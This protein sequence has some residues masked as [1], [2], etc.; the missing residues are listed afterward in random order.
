MNVSGLITLQLGLDRGKIS[1]IILDKVRVF[2]LVLLLQLLV[3]ESNFAKNLGSIPS[4]IYRKLDSAALMWNNNNFQ[5]AE[6]YFQDTEQLATAVQDPSIAV[7]IA[8]QY[9]QFLFQQSRFLEATEQTKRAVDWSLQFSDRSKAAASL[10][11]IAL[12]QHIQGNL[13]EAIKTLLKALEL[14]SEIPKPIRKDLQNRR[15]YLNNLSAFLLDL[16]DLEKGWY[17]AKKSHDIAAELKDSLGMGSSLVN[18][19]VSEM[20][21]GR[22][23]EAEVHGNLLLMIGKQYAHASMQI[24]AYNNLAELY[25]RQKKFKTALSYYTKAY[26]ILKTNPSVSMA[27]TLIGFSTVYL[28]LKDYAKANSYF[29][30]A[31]TKSINELGLPDL[32][33][34]YHAGTKIKEALGLYPSALSLR[35]KY[36]LLRDS[37]R[38]QEN[39]RMVEELEMQYN[40]AQNK[41]DLSQRDLKIMEQQLELDR[42]NLW[43][44][45]SFSLLVFIGLLL[46]MHNMRRDLRKKTRL[47]RQ[48]RQL[49]QAQL[50]AVEKERSRTAKELHDGVASLLV[51]TKLQIQDYAKRCISPSGMVEIIQLMDAAIQE[52]RGISHNLAPEM[53]LKEG[54]P[55]AVRSYCS[56]MSREDQTVNCNIQGNLDALSKD[57]Q[58]HIYRIIQEAVSNLVK[59]AS[60]NEGFVQIILHQDQ[61]SI[62]IEDDGKGFRSDDLPST[63]LGLKNLRSRVESL[64]GTLVIMSNEREG[65]SLNIEVDLSKKFTVDRSERTVFIK[66]YFGIL[67]LNEVS[68]F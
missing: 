20:L 54:L 53:M 43:V 21:L 67:R 31:N 63:G 8:N 7:F 26:A 27:F 14:S 5:E 24:Q 66:P 65:T 58:L 13:Q 32:M 12:Q 37:I 59:H 64:G 15:K 9:S 36:D 17:Y 10:N 68:Q 51:A 35:K 30:L 57:M 61:L 38:N 47:E 34:F 29:E 49:L 33:E 39:Q 46:I 42:K 11:N 25:R 1:Q 62:S 50:V 18:M 6:R 16:K 23:K 48:E 4:D 52:I 41:E 28:E 22:T 45:V 55:Y 40:L 56:R 2:L 19:M 60:A 44:G 3:L